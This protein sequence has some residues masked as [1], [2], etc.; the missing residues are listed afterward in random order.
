MVLSVRRRVAPFRAHRT[1]LW[2][3]PVADLGGVARHVLDVAEVGLPGWRLVVL[4]P[5]G[6]LA[7]RLRRAGAAVYV[8]EFGPS[9]GLRSS[10]AAL[11][12]T[13]RAL[14]PDVVHAH[15]AY[16]DIAAVLAT[17]RTAVLLATTEHGIAAD[18]AVYHGTA[19]RAWAMAKV[20]RTRLAA[21]DVAIAVSQATRATMQAKW[22]AVPEIAVIPNGVDPMPP[23]AVTGP[24][25]AAA[26]SCTRGRA[27]DGG[28]RVLSL[29][30]LSREK[31]LDDLLHAFV[32][33]RRMD[34][35]AKLTIAGEGPDRA[36]V[37][38]AVRAMGLTEAVDL[39]GF[40]D[41]AAAMA[42]ADVVVQLSVWENCSYTLL[43]AMTAGLGVV[44]TRVGG[45]PELLPDGCFAPS[46][47]P[48]GIAEAI[49]RQADDDERPCLPVGWPT[50]REMAARIV[51]EY[52]RGGAR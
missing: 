4:C 37:Q 30:R 16:A 17:R 1:A 42:E 14:R 21:T 10:I 27:A 51:A 3:V 46:D 49:V 43:D 38:A 11:R 19:W 28:L 6:P 45:N 25:K 40:V 13:I 12:R 20:H 22:S 5:E 32:E 8:A 39:P 29:A 24:G 35:H 52:E 41:P 2:V 34:P 15:L 44:A 18:D 50:R 7:K 31:G 33:L 48:R 9:A 26:S 23:D 36:S 47:D